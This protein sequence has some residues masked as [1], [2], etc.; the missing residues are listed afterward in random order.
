MV[1]TV[2]LSLQ[3]TCEICGEKSKKLLNVHHKNYDN[4]GN[5]L[6]HLTDLVVLC[7]NCHH[8]FHEKEVKK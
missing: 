6:F 5:E 3:D 8:K 2:K 7:F 4:K 1:R